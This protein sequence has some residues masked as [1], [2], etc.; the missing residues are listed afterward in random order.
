MRNYL[1]D[2][3]EARARIVAAA[4]LA[5]G[6][7]DKSELDLLWRHKIVERLGM[8]YQDFDKVVHE[9]CDDVNQYALRNENG[10]LEIGPEIIDE[11]LSEV[12]RR[13]YQRSLLKTLLQIVYADRRMSEGEAVLANRAMERWEIDL[14][15]LVK[16]PNRPGRRW[17]PQVRRR[18]GNG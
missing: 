4:L 3:P 17:P 9:F 11:M 14:S 7:L 6:S 13:D 10:E 8:S 18:N 12:H 15:D 5:D 1:P 16:A 2:S